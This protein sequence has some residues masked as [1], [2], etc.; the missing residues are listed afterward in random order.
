MRGL[1]YRSAV[2]AALV[3][4]VTLDG[5]RGGENGGCGGARGRHRGA[6]LQVVART[7]KKRGAGVEGLLWY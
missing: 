5:H 6:D 4:A 7:K 2:G 1:T 3:G